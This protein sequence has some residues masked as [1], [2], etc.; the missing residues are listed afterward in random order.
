[1]PEHFAPRKHHGAWLTIEAR[2]DEIRRASFWLGECC[3]ELDIP[4]QQRQRLELCLNEAIANIMEHGG[5]TVLSEPIHLRFAVK[6]LPENTREADLGISDTGSPFN[7]LS[8]GRKESPQSLAD[9]EP[10]GLGLILLGNFADNLNYYY[11]EGRN[12][13]DL[14]VRWF[15]AA[16]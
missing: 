9:A 3:N 10:G 11:R 1:M 14:S 12:H 13:L 4:E 8:A 7:P 15:D 5:E 6:S 2:P 16:H